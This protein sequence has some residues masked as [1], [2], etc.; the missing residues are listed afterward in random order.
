MTGGA[1]PTTAPS[2]A[3]TGI[4]LISIGWL[5]HSSLDIALIIAPEICAFACGNRKSLLLTWTRA[6]SNQR[7]LAGNGLARHHPRAL[8]SKP[9]DTGDRNGSSRRCRKL[10][11]RPAND[12]SE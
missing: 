2:I 12:A 4:D 10:R 11:Q 7:E 3:A 1:T 9:C 8:S 5:I 6:V